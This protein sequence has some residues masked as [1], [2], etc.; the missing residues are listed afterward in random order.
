[1]RSKVFQIIHQVGNGE[2]LHE[3]EQIIGIIMF[4]QAKKE[5]TQFL[6]VSPKSINLLGNVNMI[7]F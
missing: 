1:M 4:S 2:T 7:K 6:K 5:Q 3:N